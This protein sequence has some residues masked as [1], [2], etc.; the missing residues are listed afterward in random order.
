MNTTEDGKS[1]EL[2]ITSITTQDDVCYKVSKEAL[3]AESHTS[4]IK[5]AV[6]D[7]MKRTSKK[8]Y[9]KRNFYINVTKDM[10]KA[11]WDED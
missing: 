2:C 4:I 3:K 11:Y 8:R 10:E 7:H 5:S 9:C 1:N 6:Y